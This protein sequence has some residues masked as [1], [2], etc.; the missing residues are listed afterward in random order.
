MTRGL[1]W[2]AMV[3]ALVVALVVGGTQDRAPRTEAER[4]TAVAAG[5]RCPTCA[6]LSA[7][8][9]N[10]AAAKAVRDEI[11]TRLREGESESEIQAYFV[12]RF[13][14]GILLEPEAGGV[15][16]LVWVLPVAGFV[17]V[18]AVLTMMYFR[19]RGASAVPSAADRA[20]VD[21]ALGG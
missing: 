16:G 3:T 19:R 15:A 1:S 8:E 20:L 9:S 4:V 11:R 14:S 10:A 12:S 5:I 17:V 13:G 2:V 18:V 21:R 6:G 7:A